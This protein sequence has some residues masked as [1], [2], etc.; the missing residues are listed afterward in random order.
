[1]SVMPTSNYVAKN[2]FRNGMAVGID[3]TH[4]QEATLEECMLKS[5]DNYSVL[6]N[7]CGSPIQNCLKQ[8]GID[9]SNQTLPVSLG[10]R[11][12]DIGIING[13]TEYPASH[14]SS[15]WRSAPWTR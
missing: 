6:G 3:L 7:N 12:L 15:R 9:T 13:I 10:N 11:L 8:V 5:Q 14:P 2:G 4:Q 1:M